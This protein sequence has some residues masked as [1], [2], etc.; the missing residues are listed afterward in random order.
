[1]LSVLNRFVCRNAN[2]VMELTEILSVRRKRLV[3][4]AT[5]FWSSWM[6]EETKS[7]GKNIE[8]HGG[9]G[10]SQCEER[11]RAKTNFEV[12]QALRPGATFCR[13]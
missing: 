8:C 1:M 5:V 10:Y 3:T 4:A 2:R 7:R 9:D 11:E 13:V 6:D 12:F